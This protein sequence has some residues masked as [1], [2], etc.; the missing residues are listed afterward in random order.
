MLKPGL[1]LQALP[2]IAIALA[3]FIFMVLKVAGRLKPRDDSSLSGAR[4]HQ[5]P[6]KD[7]QAHDL[8]QMAG[9]FPV[10]VSSEKGDFKAEAKQISLT[11]AFIVCDE[12]LAVG[13]PLDLTLKLA[14][15]LKLQA[16]VTW[17]NRNVPRAEI[18]VSGMRVRFL[19]VSAEARAALAEQPRERAPRTSV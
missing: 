8:I 14:Q 17:N 4:H 2:I 13:A 9:S 12:P 6:Q 1:L 18:V 3:A 11:G 10:T 19:N 7:K 5:G 15:P 16:A